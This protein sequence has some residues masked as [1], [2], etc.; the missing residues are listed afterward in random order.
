[1]IKNVKVFE[2]NCF[3]LT[4][5]KMNVHMWWSEESASA[6]VSVCISL[7]RNFGKS[8]TMTG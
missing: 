1:M 7:K 3:N 4:S 2:L 8:F 5:P 6:C